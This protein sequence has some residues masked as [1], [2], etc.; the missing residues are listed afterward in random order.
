MSNVGLAF[1][2]VANML[3]VLYNEEGVQD[4]SYLLLCYLRDLFQIKW[5]EHP[6]IMT[7]II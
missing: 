7:R 3:L 2:I 6:Y 4:I 1:I 5:N